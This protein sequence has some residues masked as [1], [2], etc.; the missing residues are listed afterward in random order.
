MSLSEEETLRWEGLKKEARRYEG[1]LGQKV[2]ALEKKTFFREDQLA[3]SVDNTSAESG[4]SLKS[5]SDLKGEFQAALESAQIPLKSMQQV[6]VQLCEMTRALPSH[7]SYHHTVH[8]LQGV[9]EEK[10]SAIQ[11]LQQTFRKRIEGVQLVPSI[12]REMEAFKENDVTR[13]MLKEQHSL[14][15][16]QRR[17]AK[18]VEEAED[19]QKSLRYQKERLGHA[20]EGVW[21]IVERVPVIREALNR[22]NARRR[23]DVIAFALFVSFC[24]FIAFLCW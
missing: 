23:R 6:L 10:N 21:N 20:G 22:I 18:I 5:I 24:F 2:L 19:A 11:Q 1:L 8:R 7:H 12:H 16:T 9:Y 17:V 4:G 15:S 3:T 14:Y 13:L